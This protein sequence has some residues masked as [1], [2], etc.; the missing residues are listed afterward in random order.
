MKHRQILEDRGHQ[1]FEI[2]LAGA[3]KVTK[4]VLCAPKR[5]LSWT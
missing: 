3:D 4:R 5:P 2:E 1:P